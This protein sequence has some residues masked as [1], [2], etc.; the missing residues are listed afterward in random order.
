MSDELATIDAVLAGDRY[1]FNALVTT[2]QAPVYNLAYRMLGNPGEAE[3]AAQEA[4]L[5]A[6]TWLHRYDRHRSFKTWLLA[7]T[8]NYCI[9]RL[10]R[11]RLVWLSLDEPLPP[12]PNLRAPQAGP[13]QQ[14]IYA[15]QQDQIQYLLAQLP[16]LDRQMVILRYW[17]DYSYEEIA[18]MTKSTVSAVKSRLH[19][20]RTRMARHLETIP[21]VQAS[22]ARFVESG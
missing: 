19:R 20:A 22:T 6:F 7:I 1:A 21:G 10:R 17:Y 3:E 16:P 12:H 4:F 18:E 13:E 5:R 11:R 9:D 2:Y 14:T 15:E 8:S